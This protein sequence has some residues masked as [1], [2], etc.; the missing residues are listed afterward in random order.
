MSEFRPTSSSAAS[1][2]RVQR[3]YSCK[4]RSAYA[5]VTRR[6]QA[7]ARAS[8]RPPMQCF[9]YV[10][11]F[12]P[13]FCLSK[14]SIIFACVLQNDL[15]YQLEAL[16]A[17]NIHYQRTMHGETTFLTTGDYPTDDLR[18]RPMP[19]Y[20]LRDNAQPQSLAAIAGAFDDQQP[21][22]SYAPPP[23]HCDDDDA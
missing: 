18:A 21:S 8:T 6:T 17:E 16:L 5:S 2:R 19:H 23:L 10:L 3:S 13:C 4:M 1:A 9:L 7:A 12:S 15:Q 22:C 14:R 11:F 20:E